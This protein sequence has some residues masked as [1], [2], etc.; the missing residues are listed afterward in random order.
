MA[1]TA[2]AG[3][4]EVVHRLRVARQGEGLHLSILPVGLAH[5]R[6]RSQLARGQPARFLGVE[7]MLGRRLD[8]LAGD[9]PNT[10]RCS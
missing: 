6:P 3:G 1:H 8:P 5:L 9:G 2:R 7:R 4:G 10:L